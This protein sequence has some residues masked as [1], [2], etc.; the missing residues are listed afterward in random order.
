MAH[1]KDT[2][3]DKWSPGQLRMKVASLLGT[4][5]YIM[6]HDHE[7]TAAGYPVTDFEMRAF[8]RARMDRGKYLPRKPV[9]RQ[10]MSSAPRETPVLIIEIYAP[11][12]TE[13]VSR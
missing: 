13:K 10:E 12:D 2:P 4:P 5:G 3:L 6:M 8:I 7:K 1:P 9:N 11:R